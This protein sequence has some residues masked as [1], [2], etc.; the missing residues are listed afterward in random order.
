L[1][2]RLD[3]AGRISSQL[4]HLQQLLGEAVGAVAV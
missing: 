3:A 2:L 1:G 4:R